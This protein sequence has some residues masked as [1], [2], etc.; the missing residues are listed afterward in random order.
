MRLSEIENKARNL[1]LKET[2]MLSRKE[3]IQAIQR[4]EGN[5]VCFGKPSWD[6]S[7]H[8]CCWRLDCVK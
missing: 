5:N 8:N 1:G 4:I 2:R 6:C 7:Q 3:L